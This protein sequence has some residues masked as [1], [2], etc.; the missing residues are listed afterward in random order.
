MRNPQA[1]AFSP[2]SAFFPSQ[3]QDDVD[4][5]EC[6]LDEQLEQ[7]QRHYAAASR[8]AARANFEVQL[9]SGREDVPEYLVAQARRQQA[10]AEIRC[11][12]LAAAIEALEERLEDADASSSR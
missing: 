4:V 1:A 10:A 6:A 2:H 9:L 5:A 3:L 7:W 12:R 11:N 8:A